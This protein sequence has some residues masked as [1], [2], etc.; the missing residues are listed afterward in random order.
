MILRDISFVSPQENIL[1]DDVLLDLAE[2]EEQGEMLRLWESKEIFIVLGRIGK[3]QEELNMEHVKKDRIPVLRRS[4]G[5]GTVVQGRGCLNYSLILEKAKHR[6]LQDIRGS[7]QFILGRIISILKKEK[8][9]AQFMPISDIALVSSQKKISGNAQKR[10]RK[11]L[12][13]HGTILYDFP[14]EAIEKYLAFPKDMPPYRQGRSHRDFVTNLGLSLDRVKEILKQ[15][16]PVDRV[17][18]DLYESEKKILSTFL[19]A[20]DV[21]IFIK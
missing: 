3:E 5:G 11:F 16:F 10:G 20:K 19:S 2:K 12:L 9:D 14:I 13:H 4:S 7:Y 8:I 1:F 15:P 18:N 17:V 21:R 6:Q